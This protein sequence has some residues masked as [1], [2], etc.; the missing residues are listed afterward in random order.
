MG[1]ANERCSVDNNYSLWL[2]RVRLNLEFYLSILY[3]MLLAQ[4]LEC[5]NLWLF[6]IAL[7]ASS[8]TLVTLKY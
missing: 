5:P 7:V 1:L 6:N 3:N 2:G 4:N 8:S